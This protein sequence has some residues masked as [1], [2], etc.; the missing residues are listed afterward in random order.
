VPYS[1]INDVVGLLENSFVVPETALADVLA[2]SR[3]T[4]TERGAM[5]ITSSST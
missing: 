1:K 4:T 5:R 2:S 3:V